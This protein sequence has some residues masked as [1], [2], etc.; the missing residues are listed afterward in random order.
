MNLR[1]HLATILRTLSRPRGVRPVC[2]ECRC[3]H[4]KER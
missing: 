3:V 1:T 2:S 4:R